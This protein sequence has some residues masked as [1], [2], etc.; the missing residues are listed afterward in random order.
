M[1]ATWGVGYLKW[2]GGGSSQ[3]GQPAKNLR[4][5]LAHLSLTPCWRSSPSLR[6]VTHA[7]PILLGQVHLLD[8]GSFRA[9]RTPPR[10]ALGREAYLTK[11]GTR[12]AYY[13]YQLPTKS[14]VMAHPPWQPPKGT[15]YPTPPP[16]PWGVFVCELSGITH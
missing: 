14:H 10:C 12:V 7:P 3:E 2:I 16:T 11:L 5:N 13:L 4:Y 15:P 6:T 9:L 8:L 1:F